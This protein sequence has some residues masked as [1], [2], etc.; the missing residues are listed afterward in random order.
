MSMSCSA[1]HT[2]PQEDIDLESNPV[3]GVFVPQTNTDYYSLD[4]THGVSVPQTNTD[5]YS[6]DL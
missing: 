4:L 6:L 3:Y 5:Y 2:P 1:G